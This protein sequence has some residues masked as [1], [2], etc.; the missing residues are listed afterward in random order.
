MKAQGSPQD[1]AEGSSGS[2][3][4]TPWVDED[5]TPKSKGEALRFLH[6]GGDITDTIAETYLTVDRRIDKPHPADFKHVENARTG[7]GALLAPLYANGQVVAVQ[8][9]YIDRNGRKS[10]IKPVKQRL[11]I[12]RAPSAVFCLPYDGD[13]TDVVTCDG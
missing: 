11:S 6:I 4:G 2:Q 5:P 7:E 13:S 9:I 3:S 8:L 12:E 10:R 1:A